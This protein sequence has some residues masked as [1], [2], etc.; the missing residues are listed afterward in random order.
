MRVIIV[1][2]MYVAMPGAERVFEFI[3]AIYSFVYQSFF[4]KCSQRSVQGDTVCFQY[5]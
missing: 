4:F 2:R 3:A 5:L 1:V